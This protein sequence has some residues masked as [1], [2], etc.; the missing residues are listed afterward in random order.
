MGGFDPN[1]T[2]APIEKLL[3]D[4]GPSA[5]AVRLSE[6]LWLIRDDSRTYGAVDAEA[7]E[8]AEVIPE[9]DHSREK[10]MFGG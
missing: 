5:E 9:Q 4:L 2:P 3:F 10:N 1:Y 8:V 7:N 6:F